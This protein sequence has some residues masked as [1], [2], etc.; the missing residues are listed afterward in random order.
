VD[1][2]LALVDSF[3]CFCSYFWLSE[4]GGILG[5]KGLKMG[6]SRV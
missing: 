5:D 1:I 6:V 2:F 3:I 4:P